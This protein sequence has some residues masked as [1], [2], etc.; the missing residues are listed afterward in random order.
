MLKP[1]SEREDSSGESEVGRL[2]GVVRV[3]GRV[4]RP[5]AVDVALQVYRKATAAFRQGCS[6]RNAVGDEVSPAAKRKGIDSLEM[7]S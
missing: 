4:K 7:S 3:R 1:H 6:W 2:R 5:Q